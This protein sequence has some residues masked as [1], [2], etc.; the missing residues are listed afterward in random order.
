MARIILNTEV[1]GVLIQFVASFLA[2]LA[3]LID[4]MIM[5]WTAPIM[6][7]FTSEKS[8]IR[9]TLGEVQMMETLLLFGSII[10]LPFT[11]YSV[12][13]FGRKK[14]LILASAIFIT[15]WM[16]IIVA[17]QVGYIYAARTFQ[18]VG[19]NLALSAV[20]MYVGEIAQTKY[21]GSLASMTFLMIITGY[22]LVYSIV[23]FAPYYAASVVAI[24]ILLAQILLFS[25]MPETPYYLIIKNRL[26]EA[27]KSLAFFRGESDVSDE[28]KKIVNAIEDERTEKEAALKA[29]FQVPSHRKAF[30]IVIIVTIAQ[31]L[32]GHEIILMN[33]HEI[34]NEGGP[35]YIESTSAAIIFA[36]LAIVAALASTAMVDK[37]GRKTLLLASAVLTGISLTVLAIYF[38]LMY[39]G[40][41]VSSVSWIPTVSVMA[42]ALFDKV[43]LG[44]V[45]MVYATEIFAPKVK[46]LGITLSNGFYVTTSIISLQLFFHLKEMFGMHVPFYAIAGWTFLTSLYII[47]YVPET[48]GRSLEEIQ[49]ILRGEKFESDKQIELKG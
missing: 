34:L 49:R 43:G 16:V 35:T 38:N 11:I 7:Y 46:S 23:P 47:F 13:K 36:A 20:P 26:I 17:P 30:I 29:I 39:V 41:N 4:G 8:H 18:G 31:P 10:A 3:S 24:A 37:L 33:L 1:R 5:G 28:F 6:P 25:F 15:C 42:Y 32:A 48:K 27:E 9:M 22:I 2:T 14:S 12:N 44:I 40:Q 21:R 45:P 19:I